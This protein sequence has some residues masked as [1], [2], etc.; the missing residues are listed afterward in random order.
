MTSPG[1]TVHQTQPDHL[2]EGLIREGETI[3]RL[4]E[5]LRRWLGRVGSGQGVMAGA[6][7]AIKPTPHHDRYD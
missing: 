2:D 5:P 3:D 7:I 4:R 1:A 6:G